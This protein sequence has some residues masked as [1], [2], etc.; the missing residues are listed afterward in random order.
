MGLNFTI[1]QISPEIF[2]WR[3]NV[4]AESA[5]DQTGHFSDAFINENAAYG[6]DVVVTLWRS[7]FGSR[8]HFV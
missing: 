8:R 7:K 6:Y 3:Y 2:T 1:L 5:A 4:Y